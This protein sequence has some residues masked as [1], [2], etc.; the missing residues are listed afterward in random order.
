MVDDL[1][2]FGNLSDEEIVVHL[3]NDLCR[4]SSTLTDSETRELVQRQLRLEGT[5]VLHSETAKK[6][7]GD[8]DFDWVCVVEEDRF[9]RFVKDRF[10]R[11]LGQQQGKNKANKARDPWFNLEHVAMKARGNHIGSITDLMTSC[12][13]VGQEGLAAQLAREL[14]NALDSLKW[15][16]QPDLKLV[17]EIRQQVSQAPW[18]RYKNE[19][20]ISDLPLHLDAP[21]TDRI[22]KL[23]NHVRKDIEDLLTNKAPIEA[24]KGLVVGEEVTRPMLEDCHFVNRAY[25][26]VVGKIAERREQ[27]KKQ[28]DKAKTE[29]DSVR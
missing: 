13:A 20:R 17:A 26:A 8:F 7:G 5:Y 14:Q 16:V 23:Y 19:R 11:G 29:W 21:V 6:N 18:L 28:L 15:Q 2:P 22:G 3:N 9:P 12:R 10:S 1:L 24:F 4:N 25:A 27:L